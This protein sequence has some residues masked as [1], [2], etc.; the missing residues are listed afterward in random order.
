LGH[1]VKL[2]DW[3]L[4]SSQYFICIFTHSTSIYLV[5]DVVKIHAT[6]ML[7]EFH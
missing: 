1:D 7:F 4:S 6:C 2:Y 3:N 5:W